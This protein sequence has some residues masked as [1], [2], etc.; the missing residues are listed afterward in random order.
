MVVPHVYNKNS[1]WILLFL[2]RG[3]AD[4]RELLQMDNFASLRNISYCPSLTEETMTRLDE[5]GIANNLYLMETLEN[6][7][8]T[9]INEKCYVKCRGASSVYNYAKKHSAQLSCSES[10]TFSLDTM[11][12]S[13][14]TGTTA[15]VPGAP[16]ITIITPGSSK[17]TVQFDAPTFDG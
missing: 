16:T 3:H 15:N 14:G 9:P 6:C 11:C 8:Y 5:V 10:K 2:G 7:L 4:K 17:I 12:A 1:Q 13:T